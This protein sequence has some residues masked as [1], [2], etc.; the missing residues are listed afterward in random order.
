M[1][2]Q[3][4]AQNGRIQTQKLRYTPA[5]VATQTHTIHTMHSH[6]QGTLFYERFCTNE[7]HIL[8]TL[9]THMVH[10]TQFSSLHMYNSG[11][12]PR[13]HRHAGCRHFAVRHAVD[14]MHAVGH[15]Q[16]QDLMKKSRIFRLVWLL[17]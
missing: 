15:M 16:T 3:F 5:Y 17:A 14:H 7:T 11:T 1:Q 4:V 2:D 13:L 6:R 9:K 10:Y 8:H 12:A